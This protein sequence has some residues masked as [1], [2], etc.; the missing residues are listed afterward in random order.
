MAR[1]AELCTFLATSTAILLSF[2]T[3]IFN[4][5]TFVSH[6][7]TTSSR[8]QSLTFNTL[9]SSANTST[10]CG[11]PLSKTRRIPSTTSSNP[12]VACG[13]RSRA[14]LHR[15]S[16]HTNPTTATRPQLIVATHTLG[17][18]PSA[19]LLLTVGIAQYLYNTPY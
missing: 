19:S 10:T 2:P 17:P 4:S 18:R 15:I 6:R 11:P 8:R 14:S 9:L 1:S 13:L 3:N 5:S 7:Q 16:F 12:P